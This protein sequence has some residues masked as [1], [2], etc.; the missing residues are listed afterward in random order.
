MNM[1]GSRS[2]STLLPKRT[3]DDRVARE[4]RSGPDQVLLVLLL[5]LVSLGMIFE[6]S[7]SVA[8]AEARV[9]EPFHYLHKH[10]IFLGIGTLV[11]LAAYEVPL[12]LWMASS[13]WLL[14]LALLLLVL[15][16]VPGVGIRVNG[17]QRWLNFGALSFQV[18]EFAKLA[19]LVY[20]SAYLVR[21]GAELRTHWSGFSKPLVILGLML[22]LLQLEPDFGTALVITGTVLGVLFLAGIPL[23]RFVLTLVLSATVLVWLVTASPYRMQR[24][25][26]FMDPWAD[27]FKSGYQLTQALIA[28]GRGE[29]F[30]VG[31]GNSL[32]KQFY[33][34]EAH[35]DFV[36]A[37]IAEETGLI[38]ASVLVLLI[39]FIGWRI[40]RLGWIAT[41]RAGTTSP[42]IEY[43]GYL[44][45]GIG[46][47]F[48][49][50]CFIN[51]GVACGLLPT[52]GITLPFVSY[53][54]SSLLVWCTMMAVV[55]RISTEL[56]SATRSR[57]RGR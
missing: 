31:L 18:S 40:C 25:L 12:R 56:R 42:E 54:G 13:H 26:A 37:V 57:I 35:T 11:A 39:G 24:I 23:I 30:G 48:L 49:A 3:V 45:L 36:F 52:K 2:V 34:P 19:M 17:S 14:I 20:L 53:G 33:L 9:G 7:A 41:R 44:A 5:V 38:G 1:A 50:Q 4:S 16:L 47:M 22:V 10:V 6:A 43:G 28:F 55:L 46:L 29:W 8:I 27:Q 15:V 32:Q 21:R 51:M